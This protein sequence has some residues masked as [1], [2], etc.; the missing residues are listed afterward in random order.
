MAKNTILTIF[1]IKVVRNRSNKMKKQKTDLTKLM[2]RV[3]K[4]PRLEKEFQ[5]D[6][7]VF[8]EKNNINTNDLPPEVMEK[9]SGGMFVVDDLL[10]ATAA[11]GSVIT[12]VGT[13]A[14]AAGVVGTGIV[15]SEGIKTIK[16]NL[17]E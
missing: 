10:L 7:I 4:N 15:I 2:E 5:K 13:V 11:A 1:K 6:P 14:T 16:K 12:A 9:I 17:S 3:K 8:L